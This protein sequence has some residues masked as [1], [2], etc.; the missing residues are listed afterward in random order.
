MIDLHTH[1]LPGLDDGVRSLEEAVELAR[2]AVAGGI[3]ALVATPHVRDDYPTAA[4]E[5]ERVLAALRARLVDEGVPLR[6]LPG[7]EIALDRLAELSAD[8]LRR[9]GLGGNPSYLLVETPYFGLPLDLEDRL[10]RLRA[11]G[12]TPLLAHPER[13]EDF[14][15]D[16]DR[17]ARLVRSGTLVQVTAA[18]L[19]G[20]AG[21][22]ARETAK[23]LVAAGLAHVVASDAHSPSVRR[24]GLAGVAAEVGDE[25]LARWLTTELPA[26]IVSGDPL[27]PR[28]VRRRR[29]WR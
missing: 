4:A 2:E 9:F 15:Q 27:P 5:M 29:F 3:A 17:V 14:Q 1:I 11:S 12:I 13:N 22:R 6:V 21:K 26:A 18:S 16:I 24:G 25:Q 23:E 19:D 8:E 28:P 7:G 10:F 20:R